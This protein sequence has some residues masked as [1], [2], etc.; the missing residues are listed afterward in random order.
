MDDTTQRSAAWHPRHVDQTPVD[1]AR[2]ELLDYTRCPSCGASLGATRCGRCG[3]D[4]AGPDGVR[5]AAA[6]VAAAQALDARH[7]LLAQVRA[8]QRAAAASGPPGAGAGWQPAGPAAAVIGGPAPA[9]GFALPG[10]VL[11]G[12]ATPGFGRTGSAPTGPTAPGFAA[13]GSAAP[14]SAPTG[15]APTGF[16]PTGLPPAGFPAA[17]PTP[18]GVPP[19]GRPPVHPSAPPAPERPFDVVRL[20]VLAGAGLVAAAALV[21]A[22]FVLD[23]APV[24]RVAVLLLVTAFAVAG[25][26]TLRRIGV[27]SSAEAVGGLVAVLA[28]VDAW[29]VASLADGPARWL[30]LA[31]LLLAVGLGLTAAG[32]AVRIRSWTVAVLVLPL[33]PLCVAAAAPGPWATQLGLLAAAL[34]T[35]ARVWHRGAVRDR[36]GAPGVVVDALL[37]LAALALVLLALPAALL[38]TSPGGWETGGP[39]LAVLLAAVVA[40]AQAPAGQSGAWV[41]GSAALAVAAAALAAV[42]VLPAPMG[43]APLTGAAVW[44]L[45]VLLPARRGRDRAADPQHRAQVSGGWVALLTLTGIGVL[46]G[47]GATLALLGG[48]VGSGSPERLDPHAFADQVVGQGTGPVLALVV[49][50]GAVA[51]IGRVPLAPVAVP[52]VVRVPVPPAVAPAF[53]VPPVPPAPPVPPGPSGPAGAVGAAGA[54]GSAGPGGQPVPAAAP[55]GPGLARVVRSEPAAHLVG[56]A[57]LP[58]AAVLTVWVAAGL[59]RRWSV[60][61]LLAELALAAG[62]VEA[63]RRVPVRAP[64]APAAHPLP[65]GPWR[66]ALVTAAYAQV[67]FLAVLT[68]VSWPTTA[69]G[70][71]AVV[72]LL[73]RSRPLAATELRGLLVAAGTLYAGAVLAV[74]LALWAGWDGFGVVGAV[75]VALT[76]TAATLTVLPRVGDDTWLAV[77]VVAVVPSAVGVA[78]V[79]GDRTWWG[80]A[81]A[82]ALLLLEVVLLDTRARPVPSWLRTLAAA[83]VLP[84]LSVV[85]ICAGALLLPGSGSPVLLPVVAVL[86]AAAAVA[87]P[88][89]GDR[90]GARAPGTVPGRVRTAVEVAAAATAGVTLLLG[91]ARTPTGADTV[92]VLCAVLGAGASAV[93]Q[94]RDRRPVWWAAAVLWTGVV[95]SA[96]VWW[97]V[98]LVEAYTAPPALAAVVTGAL[99][100]RRRDRWRPLVASGAA[101]LVVPTLL[102]ALAGRDVGVRSAAL[103]GFAAVAVLVGVLDR[104]AA[105]ASGPGAV[106][107]PGTPARRSLAALAGPLVLAGAVAALAGAVRAA[108]LAADTPV[109]SGVANARLFGAALG[110]SLAGAVLLGALGLLATQGSPVRRRWS[111]APALVVGTVG[112]LSAVRPSWALV[113]T[114]LLVELA[115]LALAVLAVRAEA[116]RERGVL[117]TVVPPG[118]VLWLAALAWAIAAW[119]P[120]ELRVEVFALPLGVAL[121]A[122]GWVALQAAPERP[123]PAAARPAGASWPVGRTS[124]VAAL[125]PGI[126]ATLGPSM[127]AIWTDPLTWR[128]ILVVVLALGFMLMGARQLLR[129]PLVVGAAAL[130]VAVVSVF[131]AQI[132]RTISAGPWLLTLLAAGGLLLVLGIFAE[133]RRSAVQDGGTTGAPRTLR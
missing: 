132:G 69:L 85:V 16:A 9:P 116:R 47:V 60:P 65:R 108:H 58:V 124:S 49:L 130:P 100:S 106:G 129:A 12:P 117:D 20:F 44:A 103:L 121:T 30:V 115:L 109:A 68:W 61:L 5:I 24:A 39:A 53:P 98:G 17:G 95:W 101:L 105:W 25:T 48:V 45:L 84:T 32:L 76:L 118:W 82:A 21:F 120:R 133:R 50:V 38:V 125:T 6:S 83:L 40:R 113:W 7:A 92:L 3:L 78:A 97:G 111:L 107:V 33:V 18:P 90:V 10:P 13:P 72:L 89:V 31:P 110:W 62:F 104:R 64:G 37:A 122:I 79:A 29:V 1:A 41:A 27:G 99:L 66:G 11:P 81:G 19:T 94:R 8:A 127:L 55:L 74:L 131:A 126:V 42:S 112:A 114:G 102:L 22:F 28:V 77:L 73:L 75:A 128:A 96:L 51:A 14:G 59:L 67:A 91:V 15:F 52:H 70:A 56:R 34:V 23:E 4:L 80:A 87:A 26:L 71:V 123:G 36:F 43:T 57:L 35:L 88:A 2:R 119:S 93:A 54:A 46:A 86:A 63:A